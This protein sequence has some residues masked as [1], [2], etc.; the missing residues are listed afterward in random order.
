MSYTVSDAAWM[1]PNLAPT[2][3]LVLLAIAK[4]LI[5]ETKKAQV[6]TRWLATL[7]GLTDRTVQQTVARLESANLIR[8][9]RRGGRVQNEYWV[10]FPVNWSAPSRLEAGN[11]TPKMTTANPEIHSSP[12]PKMTTRYMK[13]V[14]KGIMNT[15][16]SLQPT[17]KLLRGWTATATSPRPPS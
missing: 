8:V 6:T 14:L 16:Q 9:N 7:T 3:K 11:P 13:G 5:F 4:V 17:P 2:E 12:T 10:Q 15:P 1:V